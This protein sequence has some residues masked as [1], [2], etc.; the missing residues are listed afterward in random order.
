MKKTLAK[1]KNFLAK[2][3]LPEWT[4]PVILFGLCVASYAIFI[5]WLKYYWDDNVMIW[6]FKNYGTE[7]L[8][9][10]D[11][12]KR[13]FRGWIYT[14]VFPILGTKPVV[15]HLV[16]LFSRWLVSAAFWLFLKTLLPE[17]KR[18]VFLAAVLFT[19]YPGFD[20]QAIAIIYSFFFWVLTGYFLSLF[21]TIKA[22]TGEKKWFYPL[23]GLSFLLAVFNIISL[24]YFYTLEI[25][26]VFV[27]FFVLYRKEKDLKKSI[28]KSVLI[29]LPFFLFLI[30][31]LVYRTFFFE[32]QTESYGLDLIANF[33]VDF[34]PALIDFLVS[35]VRDIYTAVIKVWAKPFLNVVINRNELPAAMVPRFWA[36]TVIGG[37]GTF[38][39]TLLYQKDKKEK[40]DRKEN[41]I[42]FLLAIVA[43][44]LAGIPFWLTGLAVGLDFH[45]SRFTMPYMLGACL[46]V[47]VLLD[48]IP[49]WKTLLMVGFS[50]VVGFSIGLHFY[51]AYQY[52]VD[53]EMQ[54][55]L[56]R[57]MALRLPGLEP[58][59]IIML[60]QLSMSTLE[61]THN[62]DNSLTGPVNYIYEDEMGVDELD[63]L[64]VYPNA[65]KDVNFY[66]YAPDQDYD[67]EFHTVEFHGSTSNVVSVFFRVNTCLRVL[68]PEYGVRDNT[69]YWY[70]NEAA[71]LTNFDL[72]K[73]DVEPNPLPTEI[74]DDPVIDDWCKV[75]IQ[76]EI[77]FQHDEWQSVVD[78]FEYAMQNGYEFKHPSENLIF[79]RSYAHL[80]DWE[81]A[82][83]LTRK[84]HDEESAKFDF[85]LCNV[86]EYFRITDTF[87]SEKDPYVTE[88]M[89]ELLQCDL[90]AT[91]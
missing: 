4:V 12:T 75:Y 66:A 52:R 86:W 38:L 51:D 76:A 40:V 77:D 57:Q 53:G 73:F 32:Y 71:K 80:G 70:M 78:S 20:Q 22:I 91:P 3:N 45:Q 47:A 5:P 46:L 33:Q 59:T 29:S 26:R 35:I 88:M 62:S 42:L 44:F 63:Y 21:L 79:L 48:M 25:L 6:I 17:R 23:M 49:R 19:I 68:D 34:F 85:M 24:E 30:G 84:I 10:Y 65:R 60:N 82:D 1:I 14:L 18:L 55:D 69:V 81:S 43:I 64:V 54:E 74:Y 58:N 15:W 83:E 87:G 27:V 2:F 89:E 61:F 67:Y 50:V 8:L 36:I 13:P 9:T 39:A 90:I 41:R 56:L 11:M 7:G 31:N 72:I 37:I 16:A 28:R